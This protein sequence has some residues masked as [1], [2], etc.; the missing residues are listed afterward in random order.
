MEIPYVKTVLMFLALF[1][2][3]FFA[4]Q[5]NLTYL[6]GGDVLIKE[7]QVTQLFFD[8]LKDSPRIY[9]FSVKEETNLDIAL[10]KPEI[11]NL[12]D[13]YSADVFLMG[14]QDTLLFNLAAP[15]SPWTQENN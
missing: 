13:I 1:L 2:Q 10:L 3:S 4:Y 6:Q 8:E 5:L 9:T 15:P 7:P 14:S 11:N 12:E